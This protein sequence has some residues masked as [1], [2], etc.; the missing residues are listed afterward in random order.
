MTT[1][2]QSE[3]NLF[4]AQKVMGWTPVGISTGLKEGGFWIRD[5][6]TIW[7][8]SPDPLKWGQEWRP[9]TDPAQAMAVLE[10]CAKK[11]AYGILIVPQSDGRWYL[12]DQAETRFVAIYGETLPLA[13][14][15]LARELFKEDQ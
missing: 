12:S 14:C 4:L 13:I 2:E 8:A 11:S 10:Q 3:L 6:N 7:I 15:L 5:D 1:T 9:T